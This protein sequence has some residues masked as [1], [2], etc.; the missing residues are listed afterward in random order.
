M[1]PSKEDFESWLASPVTEAV[2]RAFDKLK[3]RAKDRWLAESWDGGKPDRELLA[4]LR[5]RAEVI[6]DFRR[7]TQQDL[8]EWLDESKR[9]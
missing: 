5:A 3:Q 8:E 2:F 4:D 1:I 7:I 6:D 9:D